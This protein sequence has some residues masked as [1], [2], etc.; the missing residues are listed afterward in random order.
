MDLLASALAQALGTGETP[1]QV[2]DRIGR[3]HAEQLQPATGT[4]SPAEL[5]QDEMRQRCSQPTLKQKGHRAEYSLHHCP[6]STIAEQ[7]PQILC[8]LHRGLM[9]G[10]T[11]ALHQRLQVIDFIPRQTRRQVCRVLAQLS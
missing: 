10:L 9:D 7:N 2:G 3:Q 5:V 11:E 1:H 6:I 4:P 8:E